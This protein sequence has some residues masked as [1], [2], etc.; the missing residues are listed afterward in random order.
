MKTKGNRKELTP[1]L[2][3]I[4]TIYLCIPSRSCL[5]GW[6]K[7]IRYR[8]MEWIFVS[9]LSVAW[10][11]GVL[12]LSYALSLTNLEDTEGWGK[13]WEERKGKVRWVKR[14]KAWKDINYKPTLYNMSTGIR[15]S[16]VPQRQIGA[17]GGTSISCWSPLPCPSRLR[18]NY[19]HS[20]HSQL[21][22]FQFT[23]H[24]LTSARSLMESCG[25]AKPR[26][27]RRNGN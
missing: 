1:Y 24:F 22:A 13:A 15:P 25:L 18:G 10:P 21:L 6:G 7:V 5:W 14:M 20:S 4:P 9:L 3:L 16:F 12:F 2:S 23:R 11:L 27:K 19:G 26:G 8:G 17:E